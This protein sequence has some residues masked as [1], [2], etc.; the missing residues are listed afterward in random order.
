MLDLLEHEIQYIALSIMGIVYISKIIWI[1]RFKPMVERTPG[2][3][4]KRQAITASFFCIATPWGMESTRK[5]WSKKV[6]IWC[7]EMLSV[8]PI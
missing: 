2:K 8:F 7:K 6:G 5:K 1:L 3:G 4:N